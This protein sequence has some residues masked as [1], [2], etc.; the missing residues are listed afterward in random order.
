MRNPLVHELG[1]DKVTSARIDGQL[2]PRI[3]KWGSIPEE[4][5]D[6]DHQIQD[7]KEWNDEWPILESSRDKRNREFVVFSGAA[8]YRAVKEM[9]VE[10]V[11]DES[12]IQ[13]A[14]VAL[15]RDQ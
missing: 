3:G 8:M 12:I 5:R 6:I 15:N 4:R 11:S 14:V 7:M 13:N 9:I 2:E 1:A 10:L